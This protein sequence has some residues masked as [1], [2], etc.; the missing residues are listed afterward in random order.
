MKYMELI[1]PKKI[2]FEKGTL[3]DSYGKFIAE[4]FERGY[5]HTL[6]NSLRRLLL[7]SIEGAAVTAVRI[8]GVLHEFSTL[9]GVKEDVLEILFN[10]K[11]LRFK[12]YSPGP[13][14]LLLKVS[15][16]DGPIYGKDIQLNNNVEIVN[17]EQLIVTIDSDG[18]IEMEIEVSRGRGYLPA[19][20]QKRENL[21]LG[22]ILLDASF[23]PVKKVHYEVENA[24][25][26]HIT[27]Y[28]RLIL[29]IWTDGTIKPQDV[30]A[31]AAKILKDS[32]TIFISY[33]EAEEEKRALEEVKP[34]D[35]KLREILNRPV[36]I[37]ELSIR[38]S[39]CLKSAEIKTIGEL[40]RRKEEELL[41]YR[42]FGRKSLEEVKS[43]L[44]ELGL[45]LGME[46]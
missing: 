42:N 44:K 34:L 11:N 18:E 5:G 26:G 7:S 35:E 46:V 17:P 8:K 28:D 23:S 13:E 24:R 45:S 25:V 14:I 20:K 3:N 21:P 36:E 22:T 2:E 41:A 27:D 9:K 33:E 4:P 12:I 16:K 32:A 43:K 15:K 30:L 40:V 38:A 29:E 6:G 39:N 19:E 31:Y 1:L 10:L 37:I